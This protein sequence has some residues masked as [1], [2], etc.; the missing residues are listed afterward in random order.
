MMFHS[1][2]GATVA[3]TLVFRRGARLR[4]GCVNEGDDRAD[5]GIRFDEDAQLDERASLA[6]C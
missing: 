2:V 6:L 3:I 1:D 4:T 5:P